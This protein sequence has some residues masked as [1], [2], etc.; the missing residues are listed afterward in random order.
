[1]RNKSILEVIKVSGIILGGIGLAGGLIYLLS[2]K[3]PH[4]HKRWGHKEV[5]RAKVGERPIKIPKEETI[6]E[7]RDAQGFKTGSAVRTVQ[8]PGV[9]V[10]YDITYLCSRCN[11]KFTS[12][13]TTQSVV[14]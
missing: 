4:C 13:T 7:Y 9:A 11:K 6:A 2:T 3:C 5:F 8:L 10:T 12:T 14:E 1:M